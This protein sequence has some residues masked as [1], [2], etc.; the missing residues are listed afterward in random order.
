MS[1]EK[2]L[3][4]IEVDG[5]YVMEDVIPGEE[6][7]RIRKSVWETVAGGNDASISAPEGV[8]FQAGLIA[9][10]QSFAEH[11][12]NPKVLGVVRALFGEHVR[13]SFT[14]AIINNPGN[15]RGG[16]HSD[17]PFNQ[18][19]AG[20]VP[21]PYPDAVMHLTTIWMFSPFSIE[22]GGTLIVPG[23]HKADNNP[24]GNNGVDPSAPYPTEMNATG[25]P[26]SVLLFDSRCWHATATNTGDQPRV[27]VAVRY[28]PW[29]LNLD[30]LMPDSDERKRMVDE[31]GVIDNQVPPVPA[32]VFE[33]LPQEVKPLFR[34]W[35][36]EG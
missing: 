5:F 19:R 4:H 2:A 33:T 18:Q 7:E 12:A 32:G 31:T 34:H 30:V 16:W 22:T 35:V 14:S 26:G 28:A 3:Y 20:H 29:W 13:I 9:R 36:G 17:W 25:D 23:S 24:T 21:A 8:D 11:L 10:D 1:V 27:G 15:P 6:A